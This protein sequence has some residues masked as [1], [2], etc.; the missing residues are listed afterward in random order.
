MSAFGHIP[1]NNGKWSDPQSPGNS[2]WFPDLDC[3]PLGANDPYK[4]YKFKQ[5]ALLN[6]RKSLNLP[7]ISPIKM[8]VLKTNLFRFSCGLMGVHFYNGEPDFSPFAVINRDMTE[9]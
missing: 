6:F 9:S 1:I 2:V 3:R 4:P 7:G 5:L 8:V